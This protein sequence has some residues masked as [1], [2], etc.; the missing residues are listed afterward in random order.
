MTFELPILPYQHLHPQ[1]QQQENECN[2]GGDE[3]DNEKAHKIET[4]N[5]A[6]LRL[7]LLPKQDLNLRPPD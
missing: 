3:Y 4:K 7:F 2:E 1:T 5:A 6:L